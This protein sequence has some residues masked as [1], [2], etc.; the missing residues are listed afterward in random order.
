MMRGMRLV[1]AVGASVIMGIRLPAPP[2]VVVLSAAVR[3][4]INVIFVRNN[5]HWNELADVNTLTQM[6]GTGHPTQKE[7]LGCLV[8]HS[9]TGGDTVYVT[10]WVPA[11]DMRQLQYAVTGNCEQVPS[12]VGTWHTHPF[13]ADSAG[14][15]IK[16]AELSKQ[17]LSTFATGHDRV[18]LAAWDVDSVDVAVRDERG[19]VEHPATVVVR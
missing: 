3:D 17:D 15:A 7:Y 13:H 8:G 12:L 11:R 6:L 10:D 18:V 9:S 19:A 1:M 4:S 16:G 14:K 5:A 2:A